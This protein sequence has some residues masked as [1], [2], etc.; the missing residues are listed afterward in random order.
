MTPEAAQAALGATGVAWLLI[1][2]ALIRWTKNAHG[3][4]V[5][6]LAAGSAFL[7][8]SGMLS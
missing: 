7:V 4:G 8:M 3:W 6:M 2:V 5:L 1:G